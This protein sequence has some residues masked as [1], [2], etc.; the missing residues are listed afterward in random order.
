MNITSQGG[1][2]LDV[3]Y[4]LLVV[5]N[6]LIEVRDAP[7]QG[8]VVVEELRELGSSLAGVG[9]TPSAERNQNL[10][11]LVEGHIAVHHGAEADGCQGLDLAVVLLLYVLAQFGIAVLQTVPYSLGRVGPQTIYQLVFPLV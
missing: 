11:V 8:D 4:V 10:L 1:E 3:G 9:V 7:T 5:E 6:A 2:V